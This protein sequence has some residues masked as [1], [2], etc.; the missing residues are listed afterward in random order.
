[1]GRPYLNVPI[2]GSRSRHSRTCAHFLVINLEFT[3]V[4]SGHLNCL[5]HSTARFR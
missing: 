1:M 5:A 4:M 2:T 3:R